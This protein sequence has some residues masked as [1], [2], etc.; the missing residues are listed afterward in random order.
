M[1]SPLVSVLT[2]T[3]QAGLTL[4]RALA[5]LSW[6]TYPHWECIVV[7]DGSSDHTQDV[8]SQVT[9]P[10]VRHFRLQ[11]NMGRGYAREAAL[12]QAKGEL[13]CALDADDWFYP[14]KLASQVEAFQRNPSFS[15][16]TVGMAV[17]ANDQLIGVGGTV[18]RLTVQTLPGPRQLKFPF[19]PSMMWTELA[20]D[21]GYDVRYRRG[22]DVD[23]FLRLLC[24]QDRLLCH[25]PCL[26][27]VYQGHSRQTVDELLFGHHCSRLVYRRHLSRFP[28]D[29]GWM[30]L[31]SYL[32]SCVYKAAQ[33][34]R[35]S[36]Q[37]SHLRFP[38]AA[39]EQAAEYH[40][41][42]QALSALA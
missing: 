9:D 1:T 26:A 31:S 17:T 20:R 18:P 24:G 23:F 33:I 7:D 2:P 12:R 16:V 22:D 10:R 13:V 28:L 8:L 42:Q 34:L 36:E 41:Y 37:V 30:L 19:G 6:Q 39:P 11:Q 4:G 21:V 29:C 35:V 27:Y 32:K 14:H 5:S 15:V 25:L 3:F 40:R 38:A